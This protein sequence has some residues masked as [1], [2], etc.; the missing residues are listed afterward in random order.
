MGHLFHVSY[1]NWFLV[2]FYVLIVGVFIFG[3]LRPRKK[4]EWRSAGIAQAWVIALYAEMYGLPLTM[5]LLAGFIG[6]THAEVEQ[7]HFLGHLWPLLFGNDDLRWLIVCDVIGQTL[8]ILGAVLAVIGWR[9]I[10]RS[11]GTLVTDGIYRYIRHPQ[12]T[13]FYLFLI[14]SI[15]NWPTIITVCMLPVLCWTY[16]RLARMEEADALRE[17]GEKYREYIETTGMFVPRLGPRNIA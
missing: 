2:V 7:T 4:T 17:F 10:H 12:Y 13:G 11:N 1:Y 5:Y 15:I 14:G 16:Y 9:R 8:I 3:I 6:K